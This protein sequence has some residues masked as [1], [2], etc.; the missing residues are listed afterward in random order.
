MDIPVGWYADVL[1][2]V[3]CT[4]LISWLF[5]ASFVA[6]FSSIHLQL[7]MFVRGDTVRSRLGSPQWWV[8]CFSVKFSPTK[9]M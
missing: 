5:S 7:M 2:L 6:E 1:F 9:V 4:V 8:F 3:A